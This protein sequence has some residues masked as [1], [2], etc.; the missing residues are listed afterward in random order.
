LDACAGSLDCG[1]CQKAIQKKTPITLFIDG[2]HKPQSIQP[3]L[4]TT[5]CS[6]PTWI[7]NIRRVLLLLTATSASGRYT[8]THNSVYVCHSTQWKHRVSNI[9][10]SC[11]VVKSETIRI[12]F[13]RFAHKPLSMQPGLQSIVCFVPLCNENKCKIHIPIIA[14]NRPGK[15][16]VYKTL[17]HNRRRLHGF[18]LQRFITHKY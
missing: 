7:Q 18:P 2:A 5:V 6:A 4:P 12:L 9:Q 11:V 17:L 16:K 15:Y 8:S 14:A 3:G 10:C 1:L 13:I